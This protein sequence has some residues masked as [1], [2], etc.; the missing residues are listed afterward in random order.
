MVLTQDASEDADVGVLRLPPSVVGAADG[1]AKSV[2]LLAY[3]AVSSPKPFGQARGVVKRSVVFYVGRDV[4]A[5]RVATAYRLFS[6]ALC[7]AFGRCASPRP[8]GR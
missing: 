1:V 7:A 5:C 3:V 2:G 4:A 8:V 6:L